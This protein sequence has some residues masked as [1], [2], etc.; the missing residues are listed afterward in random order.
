MIFDKRNGR[1]FE[2]IKT[3]IHVW[4]YYKSMKYSLD[5]SFF[6]LANTLI[7]VCFL[8]VQ[9]SPN[10]TTFFVTVNK[11]KPVAVLFFFLPVVGISTYGITLLPVAGNFF[12]W[13]KMSS[14]DMKFHI[15]KCNFPVKANC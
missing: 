1:V 15:G 14:C 2:V 12:L 9:L 13:Q 5:G 4:S 8:K 7:L 6:S 10:S 11:F 3:L